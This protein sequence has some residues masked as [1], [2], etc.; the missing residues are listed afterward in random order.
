MVSETEDQLVFNYVTDALYVKVLGSKNVISWYVRLVVQAKDGKMKISFFDD[1]NVRIPANQYAP[2]TAAR[3]WT[4]S[5]YFKAETTEDNKEVSIAQK[6][7]SAGLLSLHD[8]I[9][10]MFENLK[11]SILSKDD[12]QNEW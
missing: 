10:T 12:L 2:A 9:L 1:G 6:K 4:F 8:G 11:K 3:A 5:E 7:A